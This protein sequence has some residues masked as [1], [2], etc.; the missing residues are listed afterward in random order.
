MT[1]LL[2]FVLTLSVL[3]GIHEAGHYWVARWCGV[4]VERFSIGFGKPLLSRR[5]KHGTEFALA[6]I[7]LGGYVKML[8]E[9]D[10]SVPE[11]MK[12]KAHGNQ[13]P[14]KR[15]AIAAAGPAANFLLAF[16]VFWF[17]GMLGTTETRPWVESPDN[18]QSWQ[19]SWPESPGEI[20]AVDGAPVTDWRSVQLALLERLGESG[21]IELT[22]RTASGET[23]QVRQPIDRWLARVQDP[24][25][26]QALGLTAWRPDLPAAVGDVQAGSP[27]DNAGL[28][29]GDRVS[30]V[31]GEAV[32][33][34]SEWV[35]QIRN[36]PGESVTL[37]IER[38][39][40]MSQV[41]LVP[42]S[43]AGPEG[44]TI[45]RA[46]VYA[47]PLDNPE[48]FQ[49]QVRHGPIGALD[50][51]LDE[52]TMTTG[53]T[54][55]FLAKMITGRASLENLSGPVSIAQVA[56]D[57]AAFGLTAFLS[58]LGLL[59]ISLGVLNLLPI[60]VL[61][62]GHILYYLVEIVRGRP[63]SERA[64]AIGVQIGI[65]LLI[66]VMVIAFTNDFNRL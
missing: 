25:P 63:L 24:N 1:T 44:N 16:A 18:A 55:E 45:G 12:H 40:Q 60:P 37:S 35:S 32:T 14:Q 49:R 7:P 27:A 59:S 62:G 41:V 9:R 3:I 15:I 48:Q 20:T 54:L 22:L 50:V 38:D 52:V 29:A 46:G 19:G 2:I 42:E 58:F 39:G 43:I 8:D 34:W 28:R 17:V 33:T 56:G 30:A 64:Q 5:N 26:V 31:N 6:P 53:L 23:E 61:D 11:S 66:G 36:A 47:P 65:A 21:S 4:H 51:A 57:S 13:S 10:G